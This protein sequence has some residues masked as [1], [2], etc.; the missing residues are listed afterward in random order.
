VIGPDGQPITDNTGQMVTTWRDEVP[1]D[2]EG[3]PLAYVDA[4]TGETVA[5]GTP[6]SEREGG[7]VEDVLS[8]FAVR[9]QWGDTPWHLKSWHAD[10]AYLT[11]A[12]VEV[13]FGVKVK[14]E[15]LGTT[16]NAGELERIMFGGGNFGA[17]MQKWGSESTSPQTGSDEF[18]RVLCLYERPGASTVEGTEETVESPGGRYLVV[19]GDQ[20]V[21][22]DGPRPH[23]WPYT[24][25][26]RRWDFVRLPGSNSGRTPL[27]TQIGPQRSYNRG[28]AQIIEHR[29]LVTN[30]IALVDR[31]AGLHNVRVTNQPGKR[32]IVNARSGVEPMKWLAPPDLGQDVYR[33]QELL[34]RELTELGN[35]RGTE[36][37]PPQR[38]ASGELIKELRFNSDRFLGPTMRRATEEYARL[39]EDWMCML[40]SVWSKR[41]ILTM[42]GDDNVAR[43][44]VVYPELF[45]S[46]YCQVVPDV[47][48]MLPEGRGERMAK[49]LAM[50]REGMFGQPGSPEAVKVYLD[51][52]R[53]PH[54]SRTARPGGVQRELAESFNARLVQGSPAQDIPWFPW[55]DPFVHLDVLQSFMGST[56]FLREPAQVQQ[57]FGLRWMLVKGEEARLL[58]AMAPPPSE[59]GPP[60]AGK[61]AMKDDSD[62]RRLAPAPAA[63][64]AP[65][66]AAGSRYP[67]VP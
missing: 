46:G 31:N 3:N 67:N 29:N 5:T 48:S 64:R 32:Y 47:E 24:S 63:S 51:M 40:P 9:G 66:G 56:D 59:D 41:K 54:L 18:V 44:L 21:L 55:Y 35:L 33:V 28:W 60:G 53:F 14:P 62:Q 15:A 34:L 16:G 6:H 12:E 39:I 42:A 17:N 22:Y 37:E 43:T 4:M 50:Y 36:G 11:P 57:Q 2:Q 27:E 38:D 7:L 10:L 49:V 30:P 26:I 52:A 20:T 45:K 19:T 25:P 13:T 58:A 61:A 65:A 8:P 1:F 23:R